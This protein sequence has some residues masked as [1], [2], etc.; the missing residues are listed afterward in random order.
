[1]IQRQGQY[2]N[3]LLWNQIAWKLR[4]AGSLPE[5]STIAHIVPSL[6]KSASPRNCLEHLDQLLVRCNCSQKTIALLLF[7]FL[8][9]P[10]FNLQRSYAMEEGEKVIAPRM[11]INTFGEEYWLQ[12]TWKKI[13]APYIASF[14][15]ELETITSS[16]LLKADMLQS[17]FLGPDVFDSISYRRSAIEKHE[18]DRYA[19]TLDLIIDA[20]RDSIEYLINNESDTALYLINKWYG[21]RPEIMK[22]IAIH[23]LAESSSLSADPKIE[24]LLSRELLFSVGC[25]HEVFRALKVAYPVASV[26]I[27]KKVIKA[28]QKGFKGKEARGLD[29]K[30]KAFEVYNLMCWLK[31]ADP[32]CPHAGRAF[33][34]IQKANIEFKQREH[35]DFHHWSGGVRMRG[36]ESPSTVEELLAKEPVDQLNFLLTFKGNFFDGPDRAGLLNAITQAVQRDFY[37]GYSLSQALI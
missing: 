27:R 14:A 21:A 25:V 8:T 9:T 24:W 22:R 35:P 16:H 10:Q 1:L 3:P 26:D 33:Q 17:S 31:T 5:P 4:A 36:H 32:A 12:E 11:E 7:E 29:K 34:E 18:Q 28:I 20:A 15:H 6:L 2:L 19:G 37:W 13:F 30:T 23:A